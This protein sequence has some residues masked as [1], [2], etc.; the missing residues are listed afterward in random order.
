ME[1]PILSNAAPARES[2]L[3]TD[4]GTS[5]LKVGDRAEHCIRLLSAELNMFYP[6]QM[7]RHAFGMQLPG[8]LRNPRARLGGSAP[9]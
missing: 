7:A 5:G 4:Q 9:G 1:T 6:W 3:V 2:A 8:L